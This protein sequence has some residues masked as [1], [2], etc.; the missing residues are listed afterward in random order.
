MT[1]RP[2]FGHFTRGRRKDIVSDYCYFL[3]PSRDV[4]LFKDIDFIGDISAFVKDIIPL[5]A[6]TSIGDMRGMEALL[7]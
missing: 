5:G 7:K 3:R 1:F 2:T 4:Y 6:V